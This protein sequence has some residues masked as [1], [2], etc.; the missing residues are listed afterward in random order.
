M[1]GVLHDRGT[2]RG[3]ARTLL[4]LAMLAER[5]AARAFPI[6]FL[7]L[8]ILYRAEAIARRFIARE[9]ATLIAEAL[10]AGCPDVPIPD[11]ACLDEPAGLHYG[12]VAAALLSLRLRILAAVLVMFSD[13]EDILDDRSVVYSDDWSGGWPDDWAGVAAIG[14]GEMGIAQVEHTVTPRPA[15]LMAYLNS[16]FLPALSLMRS[17]PAPS[18]MRPRTT[19]AISGS[20]EPFRM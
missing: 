6:R 18:A 15:Y 4:A 12:A 11:L 14:V 3:I 2:F 7:V 17:T 9:A 20:S 10:D 16:P 5:T 8:A 19:P 13:A 1:E